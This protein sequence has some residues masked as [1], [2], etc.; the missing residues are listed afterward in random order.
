MAK[1]LDC[2]PLFVPGQLVWAGGLA[3]RIAGHR[4]YDPGPYEYLVEFEDGTRVLVVE[5]AITNR[6]L[7]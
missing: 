1:I 7:H 2:D 6:F 5:D 3:G 4:Y